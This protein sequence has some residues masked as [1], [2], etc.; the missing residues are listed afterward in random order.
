MV[1][2]RARIIVGILLMTKVT[3]KV[4]QQLSA[5][6]HRGNDRM[7]TGARAPLVQSRISWC[8]GINKLIARNLS[9]RAIKI[10]G[11]QLRHSL[12]FFKRPRHHGITAYGRECNHHRE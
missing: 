9:Q 11:A 7:R 10:P 8:A 12:V 4:G 1:D 3:R 2:D 5:T 6:R